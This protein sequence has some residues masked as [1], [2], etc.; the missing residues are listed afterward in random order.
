VSPLDYTV[1]RAEGVD[2]EKV[3][4]VRVEKDRL[5]KALSVQKGSQ[6]L[7]SRGQESKLNS[8]HCLF[9]FVQLG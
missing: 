2:F 3:G 4:R 1:D 6:G 8:Q 7:V 5:Q 9:F